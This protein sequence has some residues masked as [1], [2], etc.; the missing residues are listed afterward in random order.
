MATM[1]EVD[2]LGKKYRL[3]GQDKYY[4]TLRESLMRGLKKP[5]QKLTGNTPEEEDF[6]ALR[7]ISFTVDEGEVVGVIGRNGAGK[8]TLLK[9]LSRIT[10][11][12]EGSAKLFGRVGSLLEVGTGFHPELTGRENIVLSGNLLGMTRSEVRKKFDEI[13]DFSGVEKFIDTP[14]KHYSSGMYVRLGFAIAAHLEPEILLVDEVLAVGDMQ[15]QKKCL[16]KMDEVAKSGR[17]VLFVSHNM[18]AI[19]SLCQRCILINSGHIQKQG[20]STSC[21]YSYMEPYEINQEPVQVFNYSKEWKREPITF[22]R[23]WIHGSNETPCL[24]IFYQ[25]SLSCCF[26]FRANISH[27][28]LGFQI[29]IDTDQNERILTADSTEFFGDMRVEKGHI[30]QLQVD[31]VNLNLMP[32]K[33]FISK[34]MAKT[35]QNLNHRVIKDA[36][37]FEVMD[38]SINGQRPC[39]STGIIANNSTWKQI[40]HECDYIE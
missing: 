2:N 10:R 24:N 36:I 39:V 38:R 6:W 17:T 32:G 4:K 23:I 34:L 29:G 22:L 25:E 11:P 31:F 27:Q 19:K 15:F 14:V 13:V 37:Q 20:K 12:T 30:Y 35:N 33:Y 8:S 1:I 40:S 18:G 7:N 9:L 16:G 5:F 21:I 26:A 3:G 28:H